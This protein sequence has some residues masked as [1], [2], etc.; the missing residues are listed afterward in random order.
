MTGR[1]AGIALF[2]LILVACPAKTHQQASGGVPLRFAR[3]GVVRVG[4]IDGA[5]GQSGPGDPALDP[6]REYIGEAWE[7]FRC[8]LLRTLYQYS[9]H[10]TRDGGAELRPDLATGPPQVS[11]DGLTWTFHIRQGI[12]YAPPLANQEI[13]AQDFVTAFKRMAIVTKPDSGDYAVYYSVIRGFED[14]AK[15][16]ADSISG[17]ATPDPHTLV[18]TL[19]VRD[20]DF[21]DRLSLAGTAPIPTLASA[22]GAKFGAATGHDSGYGRYLIASGPYMLDGSVALNPAAAPAQ[23]KPATGFPPGSKVITLVRNPSWVPSTDPLRPAYPDRIEIHVVASEDAIAAGIDRDMLDVGMFSDAPI[24]FPFDEFRRYQSDPSL[25]K[26]LVYPRDS[27]RYITLN[28][29]TPPFDDVHVRKAANFIVNKTALAA[30]AGPLSGTPSTHIILDSFEND[31]LV[32]Y[33]PY[34]T[35]SIEDALAKAE[36]QM[37]L[38]KYDKNHD[39]ICDLAACKNVRTLAFPNDRPIGIKTAR[40]LAADLALIGIK[41]RVELVPGE[42]F[43][44]KITDPRNHIAVGIA[45]AWI[46]DYFNGSQF[47]LPLFAGPQISTAF[48]IPGVDVGTCCNFSLVGATPSSLR[49]WGYSVTKVPGIDD[50]INECLPLVGRPQTQCW[51]SLDQYL[52]ETVVPWI[53]LILENSLNIIPARV[54][55]FSLDQF[56]MLPSLDQIVVKSVPSPSPS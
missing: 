39:G 27:N 53:P 37:R 22:P 35:S 24:A 11:S 42:T 10:L 56:T 25:G 20:G 1:R 43:F 41:L 14:Y 49:S 16:R 7:I 19:T 40:A 45:P 32:N 46:K 30:L 52:T 17:I 48:Q 50:R 12:H 28:L 15:G 34:K 3:G 33:D 51:T 47:V 29:A 6:S 8:C 55:N 38:S 21:A 4:M 9:G 44:M 36:Q 13:V 23:Q 18:I 2:A 5:I 26:T 31:Q 54:V